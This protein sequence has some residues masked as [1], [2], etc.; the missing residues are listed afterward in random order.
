MLKKPLF[1][2]QLKAITEFYFNF[3]TAIKLFVLLFLIGVIVA[4]LLTIYYIKDLPQPEI[5]N[6]IQTT[7]STEIY[8][9][10]GKVLL[11][12]FGPEDREIIT[13]KQTPE[14]LRQAV[15]AAEDANFYFHPGVDVTGVFRAI[16]Q[17]LM[18]GTSQGGSTLTQQLIKTTFLT[19]DK[20][21]SR[22]I[23]ELILSLQLEQKY[24]KDQILEWY[25]NRV[26]FSGTISGV[27]QA[28]KV[29]FGKPASDLTINESAIL[30]AM[31]QRPSYF[32]PFGKHVDELLKRKNDYV[33]KRMRDEGFITQEQYEESIAEPVQFITNRE[34]LL[35]PHFSLYVK[36]WLIKEYGEDFLYEN[37][38]KVYTTLDWDLQSI[39]EKVVKE[40]SARNEKYHAY[41][42]ASVVIDPQ[43]GE[44]LSMVG[45]KDFF[46]KTY[47]EKCIQNCLFDPQ[48]NM[49]VYG[50]GRQPGSTFKPFA[51]VTA[52][53]KGYSDK[54][55]VVD[56]PTNFG[57][58]GG[59]SY[60]PKNYDGLFRGAVTIRSA[61]AQ[62]LNIPAIKTILYLAGIN[63]T[64]K[65]AQDMG[66]TTLKP[67]YGPS[68]VL[69]GWEVRPLEIASAFGVF[70]ND[71]IKA[72]PHPVLRVEDSN[73][74][75]L[76]EFKPNT[77]RVLSEKHARM[78]NSI[79]SDNLARSPMF[80]FRSNLYFDA[81]KVAAKTG[82]TNDMR[83]GWTIGYT[84]RSAVAVWVGN[85]NN[86]SATKIGES[87]AGPIFHQIMQ[88]C[89]FKFPPN[90]EF[91]AP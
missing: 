58:W 37:G 71:G 59:K 51:Y 13:L 64:V 53:K 77:Q 9:R 12:K 88:E 79:L 6:E 44:I 19:S 61:L 90:A 32:S 68:I 16:K 8:D 22:K 24:S 73:G 45:S 43:T 62:S 38:L 17:N 28:S 41:N 85:N 78:I 27:Q 10:S 86:E 4:L 60:E 7:Q 52:F 21:I 48:V 91:A 55:I 1:E 42:A 5:F 81:Y 26:P 14:H 47:P 87:L 34:S 80:G 30:A 72:T 84:P 36:D 20:L 35:A 31:I 54:T 57:V 15:I 23:K 63:D 33:L 2:D 76:K 3:Q 56:E 70:G 25:L 29:Y 75:I 50:N 40:V 46:A 89:L 74:N 67:P 39:S 49:I 82:T 65:T 69:G 18:Y 83:D 66:I 11:Y